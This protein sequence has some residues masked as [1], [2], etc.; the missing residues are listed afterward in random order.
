MLKVTIREM[1][2]K[3]DKNLISPELK[4]MTLRDTSTTVTLGN[5]KERMKMHGEGRWEGSGGLQ[6]LGEGA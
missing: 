4:N 2:I 6:G 3:S 5:L 1:E